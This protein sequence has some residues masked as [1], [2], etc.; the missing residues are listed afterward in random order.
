MNKQQ[1]QNLLPGFTE[2]DWLASG[3]ATVE[4][5]LNLAT[6]PFKD[7]SFC[8]I[9]REK[10]NEIKEHH[11]QELIVDFIRQICNVGG[12]SKNVSMILPNYVHFFKGQSFVIDVPL[13]REQYR[14]LEENEIVIEGVNLRY[15]NVEDVPPYYRKHFMQL[16]D[17][18]QLKEYF[19]GYEIHSDT[20]RINNIYRVPGCTVDTWTQSF[21]LLPFL[22]TTHHHEDD[23]FERTLLTYE[24][25][26]ELNIQFSS[27]V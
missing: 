10:M 27:R 4:E 7:T 16:M 25:L 13:T 26:E 6:S 1:A 15:L 9:T 14:L 17:E 3:N 12:V 21:Y 24:E 8:Y 11:D 19:P 22:H 18:S 5:M 23:L 20:S 2:N